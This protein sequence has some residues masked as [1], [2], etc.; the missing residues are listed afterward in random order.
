MKVRSSRVLI[1]S[2]NNVSNL[3]RKRRDLICESSRAYVK[4]YHTDFAPFP[5]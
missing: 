2:G 3:A 1:V 4:T 5:A